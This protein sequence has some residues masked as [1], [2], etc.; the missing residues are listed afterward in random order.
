MNANTVLQYGAWSPPAV[1]ILSWEL[2]AV[3]NVQVKSGI[4]SWH[5][6]SPQV[7][8]LRYPTLASDADVN[9][10]NGLGFAKGSFVALLVLGAARV[11]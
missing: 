9:S 11:A 10:S 2:A 1:E 4:A 8:L 5:A 7:N 6:F 3:M